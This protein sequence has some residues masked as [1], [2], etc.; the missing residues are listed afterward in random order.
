M[1]FTPRLTPPSY[2]DL[3][4]IHTSYGGKN[5]CIEISNGS[6][7]PNCFSGD[8]KILTNIGKCTLKSLV[9]K[10][11]MILTI[12]GRLHR[13]HINYYGKQELWNVVLSNGHVYSCTANHRWVVEISE[14]LKYFISTENLKIGHKIPMYGKNKEYCYVKEVYNT[15]IVDDVYCPCEPDTHT[16]VLSGGE[17]TGQCVGYAWG[18]FM[19]ILGSTPK[20]SCGDA[21]TWYG[22]RADGYSR[23]SSPKL[24]AV[25]CWA[26]PGSWGHVAIVE[27]INSNGI[28]TTSNS[29]YS[30]GRWWLE[31]GSAPNYLN[32]SGY[33]FQ[34]FIYNPKGEDGKN[35]KLQEF[36]DEAESHI[37][38]NGG[39]S[40]TTSGLSVGQPWCAT[41]VV[42]VAKKVGILNKVIANSFGAGEICRL[43]VVNN[44][45]KWFAGPA[46][47]GSTR[48][49]PGDL[50]QFRW[51]AYYT[52]N[53]YDCDHVGIVLEVSSTT[54][55]TVEGN[56]GNSSNYLSTVKQKSY[57]LS[58][59]AISGYFRPDWSKVGGYATSSGSTSIIGGQL[60]DMVNTKEDAILREVGYINGIS[61]STISSN[62]KLSV[63]NYTTALGA[64]FQNA[65]ASSSGSNSNGNYNTDSLSNIP[66]IIV[67]FFTN[68]GLPISAGIGIA[69]N[70]QAE[71]G[72]QIDIAA[73]DSNGL[74]SGGICQWNGPNF[75]ALVQYCPDWKTNL[76]GQLNFLWYDMTNR[77]ASYL[78]YLISLYYDRN[79]TFVEALSSLSNSADG[80]KTAAD[81]FVRCYERPA[82]MDYQSEL[83]Q[84]YAET[85]WNKV[86]PQL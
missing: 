85:L 24:G 72:F 10:E 18:R 84:G 20:L 71:C 3:N 33:I 82:N 36:L 47:G 6:V 78:E 22:Y 17:I 32:W 7:L 26:K 65:I 60:Y 76:T 75:T 37:G 12:D 49:M 62:I 31:Y 68:K 67:E 40:W 38:D 11:A 44:Y 54:V 56:T 79:Q 51:S 16:C 77:N 15:Y 59:G 66:R 63:V 58:S 4:W 52:S 14:A 23:G 39:W 80:S 73:T 50:I 45:G 13:A 74:T 46:Q 29:G 61:P 2:A 53:Q 27:Q 28:V 70:V 64:F 1:A 19:E 41:F 42:A 8:T 30:S 83:R 86:V 25:A 43:G 57:S 21:G 48:P 69:A 34:G 81:M 55:T 35:N 9:Y 5:Q